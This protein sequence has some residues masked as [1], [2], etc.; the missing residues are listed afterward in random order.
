MGPRFDVSFPGEMVRLHRA[1][2]CTQPFLPA[3][4]AHRSVFAA[5]GRQ[6]DQMF[7][8]T[9]GNEMRVE[10]PRTAVVAFVDL[11]YERL[12]SSTTV[13]TEDL[14]E[15]LQMCRK[16]DVDARVV[17]QMLTKRVNRS[18]DS[19]GEDGDGEDGDSD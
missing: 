17:V 3:V 10:H 2:F 14:L 8:S 18:G 6:F 7:R 12:D 9:D 13:S 19:E 15:A 16:Y 5:Q 1:V 4:L 11:M